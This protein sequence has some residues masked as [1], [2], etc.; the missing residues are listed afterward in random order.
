MSCAQA[1]RTVADISRHLGDREAAPKRRIFCVDSPCESYP[2]TC[3]LPVYA[4]PKVSAPFGEMRCEVR[5]EPFRGD[6]GVSSIW[7][8]LEDG[9]YI[10]DCHVDTRGVEKLQEGIPRC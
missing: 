10:T 9:H 5:G 7:D 1:D 2:S 3:T 4:A 6:N 8:R